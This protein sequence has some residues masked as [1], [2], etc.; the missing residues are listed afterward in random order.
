MIVGLAR[1]VLELARCVRANTSLS[2]LRVLFLGPRVRHGWGIQIGKRNIIQAH[3]GASISLGRA[4][5]TCRDVEI[6]AYDDA[7]I[8]FADNTYVGHGSTVAARVSICVGENTMIA[9]LV[10]IR[11]HNHGFTRDRG[12][13]GFICQPIIIG[14]NCWIGSKATIVAGVT[15]GDSV[16]VGANSVVTKSFGSNVVL[17]GCPAR[18][19]KE[20]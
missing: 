1:R 5:S 16:V 20:L 4:F 19:L 2:R 18:V 15:L 13:T 14:K 9:D 12:V 11:D 8:V 10:S 17:G 7:E 3:K 6:I